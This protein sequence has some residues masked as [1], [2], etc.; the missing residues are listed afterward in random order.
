MLDAEGWIAAQAAAEELDAQSSTWRV[1]LFRALRDGDLLKVQWCCERHPAAIHE[2]FT[3]DM[4]SWELEWDSTKWFEFLDSTC[5]YIATLHSHAH[6]VEWLLDNGVDVDT[7]CYAG[8]VAADSIGEARYDEEAVEKIK[9]L[10]RRPKQPPKPPNPPTA[11]ANV[12]YE[13]VSKIVY[14]LVE[15]GDPNVPPARE[16]KRVTETVVRCKIVAS[17]RSYWLPPGTTFQLCYRIKPDGEG[18]GV[19][20]WS[21]ETVHGHSKTLTGMQDSSIYELRVRAQNSAGWSEFSPVSSVTTP[22]PK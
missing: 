21:S 19:D 11:R 18:K 9:T 5:L 20:R 6:V 16:A 12:G 15:S 3:R 2:N 8:Q 7:K 17:W 1:V 10:L 13:D 22:K 14:E 4:N